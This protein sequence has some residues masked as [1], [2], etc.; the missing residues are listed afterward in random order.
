MIAF[1][2]NYSGVIVIALICLALWWLDARNSQLAA[3][4]E[5]LERLADSKD[6]QIHQLRGENNNLAASIA[7]FIAAVEQQNELLE[8]VTQQRAQA[9]QQNRA[10]QNEIIDILADDK[11]AA[12]PVPDAAAKRLHDAARAAGG[13]PNDRKTPPADPGHSDEPSGGASA[14]GKINVR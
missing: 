3:T 2:K 5:R 1:I 6:V 4:N 8:S 13:I 14:P 12:T 7:D 9:E 11:C 10:F